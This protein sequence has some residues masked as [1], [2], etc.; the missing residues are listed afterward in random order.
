[1]EASETTQAPARPYM[2]AIGASF[3]WYGVRVTSLVQLT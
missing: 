2:R 3:F 1:M